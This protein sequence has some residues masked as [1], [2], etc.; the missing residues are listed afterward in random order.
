MTNRTGTIGNKSRQEQ[1]CTVEEVAADLGVSVMYVRKVKHMFLCRLKA[2]LI[3]AG[4]VEP[5]FA[6]KLREWGA[7]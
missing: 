6:P 1:S 4:L 5:T 2:N 7:K 3:S